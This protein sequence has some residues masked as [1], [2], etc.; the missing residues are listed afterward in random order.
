MSELSVSLLAS[1]MEALGLSFM[2]ASLESY[3]AEAERAEKPLLESVADLLDLEYSPRKE[4]T[5]RTRLKL[6]GIPEPKRLEDFDL[7]WLKGGLSE[8]KFAELVSLSFI[9]R[10]ENVILLGPSGTGKTHLL[11]GLGVKACSAGF[12]AYYMSCSQAVEVLARAREASR[13]KRKLAWLRKPH[14]LLIDEVG[15]E[16]LTPEQA[17]LVFQLVATRYEHGSMVLTTN[18]PFGKWGEIMAD[19][20]VATATLDRLLHHAHVLS[21]KGD[22]YRMK[23]RLKLGVVDLGSS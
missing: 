22:S 12:T 8:R 15:Y 11:L 18:K 16:N 14:L 4:R 2:A 13:L 5:A 9:E 17:T 3:F 19:D 7:A 6:S 21:L 20:A 10:K 23:E 1:R